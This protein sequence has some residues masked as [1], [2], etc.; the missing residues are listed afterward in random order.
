MERVYRMHLSRLLA[1]AMLGFLFASAFASEPNWVRVGMSNDTTIYVDIA[2]IKTRHGT[3]TA[4]ELDDF[5]KAQSTSAGIPYLSMV[6]LDTV[7]CANEEVSWIS[8][9]SYKAH[10]GSGEISENSSA[11]SPQFKAPRPGTVGYAVMEFVCKRDSAK[12]NKEGQ[13]WLHY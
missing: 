3:L 10:M 6:S 9:V 7:D 4:W 8:Y 5:D 13:P 11:H 2:N 12:H 1:A